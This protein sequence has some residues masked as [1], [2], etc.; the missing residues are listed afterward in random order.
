MCRGSEGCQEL[1]QN[2]VLHRLLR[3]AGLSQSL[4]DEKAISQG[5]VSALR[6][7]WKKTKVSIVL[8]SFAWD[9]LHMNVTCIR[10]VTSGMQHAC[11]VEQT[12]QLSVT[13]ALSWLPLRCRRVSAEQTSFSRCSAR[14]ACMR[15]Q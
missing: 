7:P 15:L 5:A 2:P 10:H 9:L 8:P 14:Q 3:V 13:K 6:C 1:L 4:Q 12:L 11:C